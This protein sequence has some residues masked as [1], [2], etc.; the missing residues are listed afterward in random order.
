MMVNVYT[1]CITLV[2]LF[3]SSALRTFWDMEEKA[4]KEGA[5]CG[6]VGLSVAAILISAF[7]EYS[8]TA[9]CVAD[10]P[11]SGEEGFLN[12]YRA[13]IENRW[14]LHEWKI[15]ETMLVNTALPLRLYT[16]FSWYMEKDWSPG[17]LENIR[18]IC[19]LI[20]LLFLSVVVAG[21]ESLWHG[22]VVPSWPLRFVYISFPLF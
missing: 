19:A 16:V 3:L 20:G 14:S 5:P 17:N 12:V 7:V 2:F 22:G 8:G 18:A 10:T 11:R 6:L 1:G 21:V 13:A 4:E 15:V 9:F